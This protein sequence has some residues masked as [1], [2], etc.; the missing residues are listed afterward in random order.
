VGDDD[1]GGDDLPLIDQILETL[2]R[3]QISEEEAVRRVRS[4]AP[5]PREVAARA[6]AR[7]MTP[8]DVL[9][10][11]AAFL[12]EDLEI[13]PPQLFSNLE[14]RR[15]HAL[16]LYENARPRDGSLGSPEQVMHLVNAA[17]DLLTEKHDADLMEK[18]VELAEAYA[19]DGSPEAEILAGRVHFEPFSVGPG[20]DSYVHCL[21][22]RE[23]R[24]AWAQGLPLPI[25]EI[26]RFPGFQ[27]SLDRAA[28]YFRQAANRANGPV[29]GRALAYLALLDLT[30]YM[31]ERS[32]D[33]GDVTRM[34]AEADH[35]L[36]RA[37]DPTVW[38][39]L[40]LFA[41]D[42]TDPLVLFR[43][44]PIHISNAGRLVA[45][46]G[47]YPT[48]CLYFEGIRLA[49]SAGQKDKAIDLAGRLR[50]F[51]PKTGMEQI[52]LGLRQTLA[53]CLP[54]DPTSCQ[55]Y[56]EGPDT[57]RYLDYN[58]LGAA[59]HS[60][61]HSV[62]DDETLTRVRNLVRDR[63]APSELSQSLAI[64][65]TSRQANLAT[66]ALEPATGSIAG[67]I[68]AALG[69]MD[70][71]LPETATLCL[72]ALG[73]QLERI[74]E[75]PDED[76]VP[77]LLEGPLIT[78]WVCSHSSDIGK[79]QWQKA[80][81]EVVRIC[82]TGYLPQWETVWFV[83]HQLA[84]GFVLAAAMRGD[85]HHVDGLT[86]HVASAFRAYIYV[87]MGGLNDDYRDDTGDD[88]GISHAWATAQLASAMWT[89]EMTPGATPAQFSANGRRLYHNRIMQALSRAALAASEVAHGIPDLQAVLPPGACLL[90]LLAGHLGKEIGHGVTAQLITR[91]TVRSIAI[92]SGPKG[93]VGLLLGEPGGRLLD[94]TVMFSGVPNVI[95]EIQ[96]EPF[97]RVVSRQAEQ[98][99]HRLAEELGPALDMIDTVAGAK[100]ATT[101]YLWP[102][103][104]SHILPFWLLP[105]GHGVLAD[106]VTVCLQPCLEPV[107]WTGSRPVD[108]GVLAVASAD[109]GVPHGLPSEPSTETSAAAIAGIFGSEPLLGP[110][111]TP[112][113]F[114]AQAGRTP[115][116]HIA[117][118][119]MQDIDAPM[120]HCLFLSG[121]DG[122]LFADQLLGLDLRAV[123]L[124]TIEACES[125]LLRYDCEDNLTG[126]PSLLLRSGAGAVVG[127]L[128]SVR[129]E[130]SAQFF[131]HLYRRLQLSGRVSEA[132]GS[133]QRHTR[134]IFPRY[135]DWGAFCLIGFAG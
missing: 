132:F 125:L 10:D 103:G 14:S 135:L 40:F 51:L 108:D 133:A 71:D 74:D 58:M 123:R 31:L 113:A 37:E 45:T 61:Q 88:D 126:L 90:T 112:E 65:N 91:Q 34:V 41:G 52:R 119:G 114:L 89:L 117:A 3:R 32:A 39:R 20:Y 12:V 77:F 130:V 47:V 70:L 49:V 64:L 25:S 106:R 87:D 99:L 92:G 22:F 57:S 18:T 95:A 131:L 63:Q 102:H 110:E 76:I 100:D 50:P 104:A 134:E 53:H 48:A 128:W 82:L 38:A 109:G 4:L 107:F 66:L 73:R 55:D 111:A 124:V 56:I 96:E 98:E 15:N 6:A 67:T 86:A 21:A 80:L 17:I 118:H 116:I 105:Y 19:A 5:L 84:K 78:A 75:A 121:E 97:R 24:Q 1:V 7:V 30:G 122:R 36:P 54:G 129:P 29:R 8:P 85:R 115:Y 23:F 43:H 68:R 42:L 46:F 9:P 11:G 13:G 2:N 44:P 93:V 27:E 59:V 33:L 26:R 83:M 94:M 60:L 120:F 28:S 62:V 81:F 127:A 79:R 16:L 35:L 101:L 72:F 69:Y